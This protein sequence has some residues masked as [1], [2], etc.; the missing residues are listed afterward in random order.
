MTFRVLNWAICAGVVTCACSMRRRKFFAAVGRFHVRLARGL[1][2]SGK[3]IERHLYAL[4][5]DGVKADLEARQHALFRHVIQLLRIV[6]RQAGVLGI[7]RVRLQ[8]RRRVRSQRAVHE[9]LEHA[10]VQHQVGL[11]MRVALAAS[12]PPRDRQRAAIPRCAPS[13]CP[14]F[15]A[16]RRS[17][18]FPSS[19]NNPAPKS[20]HARPDRREPVPEPAG[21]AGA[22]AWE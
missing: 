16:L 14:L 13:A 12:T 11:R 22:S 19:E 4:V 17:E 10:G 8:H 9:S 5:A 6:A 20:R 2:G 18:N 15:P 21:A 7:I 1:L 3:G